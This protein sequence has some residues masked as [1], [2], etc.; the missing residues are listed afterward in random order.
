MKKKYKIKITLNLFELSKQ[1][2][3]LNFKKNKIENIS[4][5]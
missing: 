4:L 1:K 3:E 2:K 5:K